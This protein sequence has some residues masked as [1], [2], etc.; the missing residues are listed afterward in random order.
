[1]TKFEE[2]LQRY[3][4]AE[5][6]ELLSTAKNTADFILP[7]CNKFLPC[8]DGGK[9]ILLWIILSA[10]AADGMLSIKERQFVCELLDMTDDVLLEKIKYYTPKMAELADKFADQS[11]KNVKSD[12]LRLAICVAACDEKIEHKETEFIR[13]ILS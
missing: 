10:V 11:D 3:V 2:L 7:D 1:M 13:R 4:N 5:Y 6:G 9:T 12:V 8:E